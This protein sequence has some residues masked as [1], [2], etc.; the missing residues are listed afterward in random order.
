MKV[1]TYILPLVICAILTAIDQLVKH[2]ITGSLA[3]YDSIPVIKDVFEIKYIQNSGSAWGLLSGK[4]GF[5][6]AIT[7]LVLLIVFYVYHNIAENSRY[8]PVRIC[9]IFLL[10]GALGNMID[11]IVLG[12][13]IDFLY[14]KLINFPVFNVAD[15][16]VTISMIVLLLLVIFKYNT[17]DLDV[18]LGDKV[19]TEDGSYISKKHLNRSS[20]KRDENDESSN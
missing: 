4:T 11:R 7:I 16:Y 17:D 15:M 18:M 14:F 5:L 13:V 1:K 3:L 20:K 6:L 10:A 9:L 19:L 8:L 12:Y 2:I